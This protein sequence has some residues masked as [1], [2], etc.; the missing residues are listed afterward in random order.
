MEF[1]LVL[2]LLLLLRACYNK[3]GCFYYLLGGHG[4]GYGEG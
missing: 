3:M 2:L 4:M 1:I